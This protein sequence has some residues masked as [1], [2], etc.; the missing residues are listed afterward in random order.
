MLKALERYALALLPSL[1]RR[2]YT[3][4]ALHHFTHHIYPILLRSYCSLPKRLVSG[5]PAAELRTPSGN[6]FSTVHLI[7][8]VSTSTP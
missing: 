8:K 3:V 6:G 1:P 7:R 4:Y 2:V 5:M